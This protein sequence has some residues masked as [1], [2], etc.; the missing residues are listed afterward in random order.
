MM[1]IEEHYEPMELEPCENDAMEI[2]SENQNLNDGDMSI[3]AQDTADRDTDGHY[4]VRKDDESVTNTSCTKSPV[5][6]SKPSREASIESVRYSKPRLVVVGNY[7][8][9]E[10]ATVNFQFAEPMESRFFDLINLSQCSNQFRAG[11]KNRP[12]DNNTKSHS[13]VRSANDFMKLIAAQRVHRGNIVV[14]IGSKYVQTANMFYD[15]RVYAIRDR[16]N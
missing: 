8:R 13:F 15:Q 4:G 2:E 1:E 9:I 7:R 12:K 10:C 5:D 16:I 14:D 6:P 3:E 11:F